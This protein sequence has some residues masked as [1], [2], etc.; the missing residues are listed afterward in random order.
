MC[1]S[2]EAEYF[3]STE[4]RKEELE[5]LAAITERVEARFAEVSGGVT[6]R[7]ETDA[8]DFEYN[9][10]TAYDDTGFVASN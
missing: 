9:N 2:V 6:A 3:T 5:L 10:A 7:G 8:E 1:D 4:A